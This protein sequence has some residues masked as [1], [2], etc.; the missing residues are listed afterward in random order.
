MESLP[1]TEEQKKTKPEPAALEKPS[2][3][4]PT[5]KR[6]HHKKGAGL[7]KK[8]AAVITSGSEAAPVEIQEPGEVG[9]SVTPHDENPD[10]LKSILGRA[11]FETGGL[12]DDD[13]PRAPVSKKKGGKVDERQEF[14]TLLISV[15]VLL[16][17]FV[18]I[19]E[20]LK[21]SDDEVSILS[22]HAAGLLMRH[23]PISGALTE[24]AIDIIGILAVVAGWYGRVAP[25]LKRLADERKRAEIPSTVLRPVEEVSTVA[26]VV[27][28]APD[29]S[30]VVEFLGKVHEEHM[31]AEGAV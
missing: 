9:V 12:F 2:I 30:A 7:K 13:A 18:N 4:E 11:A 29:N 6:S 3:T 8:R 27:P 19:P 26:P 31:K 5:A 22:D 21:P 17:T 1:A 16:L 28:E 20:L 25:E 24:D 23:L 14:T 15:I 10:S